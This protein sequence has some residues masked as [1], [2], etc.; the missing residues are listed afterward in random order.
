MALIFADSAPEELEP[1]TEEITEYDTGS[2]LCIENF[3]C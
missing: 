1:R 2:S 3:I